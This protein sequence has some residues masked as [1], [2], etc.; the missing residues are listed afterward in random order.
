MFYCSQASVRCSGAWEAPRMFI[1]LWFTQSACYWYSRHL[2][3]FPTY[4]SIP[5]CC[6]LDTIDRKTLHRVSSYVIIFFIFS[7]GSFLVN[8]YGILLG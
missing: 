8:V 5:I 4:Q 7:Y 1:E 2:I 3:V 6:L